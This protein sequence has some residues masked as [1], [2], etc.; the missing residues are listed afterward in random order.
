MGC[1]AGLCAHGKLVWDGMLGVWQRMLGVRQPMG[2]TAYLQ[3]VEKELHAIEVEEHLTVV[4]SLI[5]DVP[6]SAPG[7]LHDLVALWGR[8]SSALSSGGHMAK[9]GRSL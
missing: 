9:S 4:W 6:Q 2:G 7:E 5:R 8:H 1:V 3:A